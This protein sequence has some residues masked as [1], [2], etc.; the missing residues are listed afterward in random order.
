MHVRKCVVVGERRDAPIAY[1]VD[2]RLRPTLKLRVVDNGQEKR[3]KGRECLHTASER[4]ENTIRRILPCQH[5]L[6]QKSTVQLTREHEN[7]PEYIDAR[8]FFVILSTYSGS[9]AAGISFS[10]NARAA[11]S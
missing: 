3:G 4:S 9:L 1:A 6:C 2:F 10:R 8:V 11:E 7:I 5:Q